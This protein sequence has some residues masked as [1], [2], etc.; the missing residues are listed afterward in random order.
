MTLAISFFEWNEES[1]ENNYCGMPEAPGSELFGFET[2][3]RK[4]WGSDSLIEVGSKFLTQLRDDDLY[5]NFEEL[6]LFQAELL[7]IFERAEDLSS[8]LEL[9][10]ED[11]TFRI[12]NCMSAVDKAKKDRLGICIS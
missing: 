11:L 10:I 6:D 7:V 12:K 5:V 2:W 1:G 3:R 8:K 4:V 9:H